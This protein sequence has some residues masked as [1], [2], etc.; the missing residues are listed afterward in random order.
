MSTTKHTGDVAHEEKAA[1]RVAHRSDE[2]I[3]F[4]QRHAIESYL[5]KAEELAS[6]LFPRVHRINVEIE[7]DPEDGD[8]YLVLDVLADGSEDECFN[9]HKS[10]RASGQTR[11]TGHR[12]A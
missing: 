3:E 2:V 10:Y 11:L 4:C 1:R 7:E 8:Q 5:T 9:A 12:F 6:R